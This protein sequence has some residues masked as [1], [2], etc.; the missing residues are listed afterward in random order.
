M[1]ASIRRYKLKSPQSAKEGTQIINDSF[2][3]LISKQP[4]FVAYYCID[5]GDGNYT[6]ISI[7]ENRQQA[8]KSNQ[9]SKDW[10]K[11]VQHLI[12]SGPDTTTGEVVVHQQEE[13]PQSY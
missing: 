8:E 7:F 4:G 2:V 9:V 10:L 5:P 6:T 3:P 1:Y 13:V 11:N 12:Q